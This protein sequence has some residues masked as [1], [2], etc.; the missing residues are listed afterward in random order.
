MRTVVCNSKD[1]PAIYLSFEP[2]LVCEGDVFWLRTW[3]E[4]VVGAKAGQTVQIG[5]VVDVFQPREDGTLAIAEPDFSSLPIVWRQS[6]TSTLRIL[7]LQRDTVESFG[8][9]DLM[10]WSS[11][12][13][14]GLIGTDVGPSCNSFVMERSKP[15][16]GDSG[17][18][19]GNLQPTCNYNDAL[20]LRRCSLYEFG[21]IA[22]DS[23]NFLS[24]PVGSKIVSRLCSI[25]VELDGKP[26]STSAENR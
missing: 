26:L 4:S 11:M 3:I 21:L 6:V 20:N 24:L 8:L 10:D 14:S 5:W 18:F 7:R 13:Q 19:L 16:A 17:W 9:L 12:S 15:D 2:E 23:I 25:E 1:G 22:P